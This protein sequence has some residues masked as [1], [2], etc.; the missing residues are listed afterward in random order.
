MQCFS[1]IVSLKDWQHA[2][3]RW[4]CVVLTCISETDSIVTD[5]HQHYFKMLT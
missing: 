3:N 2:Q 4:Y 1:L 5:V